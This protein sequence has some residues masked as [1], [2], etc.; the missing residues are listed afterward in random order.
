MLDNV[1]TIAG[2]HTRAEERLPG[3]QRRVERLAALAARPAF[4]FS[5]LLLIVAWIAGN[6][7]ALHLG[8]RPL[9]RPPFGWL[10]TATSIASLT[11]AAVI[12]V[13]QHRLGKRAE[14]RAHLDL[15]LNMLAE[16]KIAKLIA[17]VEELRRD[18]PEVPNRHDAEAEAMQR[19]ADPSVVVH[20]IHENLGDT[21]IHDPTIRH[22]NDR[23]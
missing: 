5:A 4:L 1:E 10:Q 20:A 18:L 17:L 9:D 16:Q 23:E 12:V 7:L 15:Q 22:G 13:T 11:L 6:L 2:M 3:T 21:D 19:P 14:Y 8:L